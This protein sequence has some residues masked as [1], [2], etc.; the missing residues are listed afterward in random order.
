MVI[1][2]VDLKKQYQSLK[3]EI[4]D[5]IQNVKAVKNMLDQFDVKS[6]VQ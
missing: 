5:A 6:K 4:D 2:F 3:S 1:P